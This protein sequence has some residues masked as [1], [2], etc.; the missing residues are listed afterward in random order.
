[1]RF[2]PEKLKGWRDAQCTSGGVDRFEVDD[3]TCQSLLVP[4]LYMT[5]EV[6][7]YDG[8]CGGYNLNFAW[9]TGMAAGESAGRSIKH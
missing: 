7:D 3:E 6:L 5:G 1:M 8:P 9:L 2:K 4:G